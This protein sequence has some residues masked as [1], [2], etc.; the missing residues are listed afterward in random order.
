MARK[1]VPECPVQ[2]SA[3]VAIGDLM[4][5]RTPTSNTHHATTRA[6]WLD[7]FKTLLV[8]GMIA[9]HVLQLLTFGPSRTATALSEVVN[10]I[11][12]SGFMLAFGLGIGLSHDTSTR[13]TL[14]WQRVRPVV[15]LLLATYV[16]SFAFAILVDR[17]AVT[18]DMAVELLPLTR[19]F[20]WSEFLASFFV[21][22]LLLLVARPLFVFVA[23]RWPP[24]LIAIALCGLSTLLVTSERLPVVA[25]IIGTTNFASFP[26][27][28][29]LPWFLIGIWFGS[30][31]SAALASSARCGGHRRLRLVALVLRRSAVALP[32]S[33]LFV[34]GPALLLFAYLAVAR[35]VARGTRLPGFL[36]LP[37]RHVL[38]YLF[39][40]NLAIFGMR[41]VYGRFVRDDLRIVIV[42]LAIIAAVT[43]MWLVL[44]G[45]RRRTPARQA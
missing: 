28:A 7:L 40:S 32:P 9:A 13:G 5:D 3:E 20:G 26:L 25:T 11:T 4:L 16:S 1:P 2:A 12:F 35:F 33:A 45:V 39:I 14:S 10:L 6:A 15:L 44:E 31:P 41:R 8:Y 36:L 22:Y 37:G 21:L 24:L 30:R 34:A 27:L 29:Y 42:A 23:N 18:V 38:S 17:E 19:L 43:L